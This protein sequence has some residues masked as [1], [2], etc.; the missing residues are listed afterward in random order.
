M[1]S[2]LPL[3]ALVC[4]GLYLKRTITPKTQLTHPCSLEE[5]LCWFEHN[6]R[7]QSRRPLV[8]DGVAHH[9]SIERVRMAGCWQWVMCIEAQNEHCTIVLQPTKRPLFGWRCHRHRQDQ[10]F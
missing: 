5:L 7:R 6:T 4:I 9:V 10:N 8:I 1:S 3:I 2:Y